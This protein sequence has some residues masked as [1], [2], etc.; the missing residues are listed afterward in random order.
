MEASGQ[1]PHSVPNDGSKRSRRAWALLAGLVVGTG[2]GLLIGG[3]AFGD[4]DPPA[5]PV[6]R[7]TLERIVDDPRRFAGDLTLVGGQVREILSPRAF[8]VSEPGFAGEELLVVTKAELAAPTR[9]GTRPVLEGDFVQV[10]GEVKEFD[11]A[12]FERDLGVDLRLEFDRFL[13][14]DLGDRRGDPAVQADLVTFSPRTTP[15]A[16]ASTAEEIAE[17]PVDYN[18]KIVSVEGRVTDVLPS[19]ALLIDGELIAL[20]AD[21][22]QR[23]PRE[24]DEIRIVGPVRR[25]DPDQLR[26]G[27]ER[28]ADDGIFA[29]LA[30][31]PAV[32]AQSI[33]IED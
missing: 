10:S 28:L 3:V 7:T 14:D 13:G 2:L 4:E 5:T 26:T 25:F 9:S 30:N 12:G 17:R 24:G 21:F 32:V 22:A 18:R 15:V 19:G 11:V 16:E 27:G 20:T 31:R 1:P 8:T 23:R 29:R 6:A 33:E